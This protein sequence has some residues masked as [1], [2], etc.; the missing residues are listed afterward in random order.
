M[1]CWSVPFESTRNGADRPL[2]IDGAGCVPR[3]FHFQFNSS[4]VLGV[5]QIQPRGANLHVPNCEDSPIGGSVWRE[6]ERSPCGVSP[7][8]EHATQQWADHHCCGPDLVR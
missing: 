4:S 2:K 7:Q 5:L 1:T 3:G 6:S 8:A